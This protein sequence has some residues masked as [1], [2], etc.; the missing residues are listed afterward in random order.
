[1]Q[2]RRF[3][4]LTN[5]GEG[6]WCVQWR[7]EYLRTALILLLTFSESAS[8]SSLSNRKDDSIS[9]ILNRKPDFMTRKQDSPR[10][11]WCAGSLH[12]N[13]TLSKFERAG[14]SMKSGKD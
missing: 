4:V 2:I 13:A 8:A 1:M 10:R 14:S 3:W 6:K 7:V 12:Q 5:W 11:L 9:P